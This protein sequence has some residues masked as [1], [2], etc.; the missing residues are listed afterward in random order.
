MRA[1]QVIL[2]WANGSALTYKTGVL[3]QTPMTHTVSGLISC[4]DLFFQD[5]DA[6]LDVPDSLLGFARNRA[7]PRFPYPGGQEREIVKDVL[8]GFNRMKIWKDYL[9]RHSSCFGG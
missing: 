2:I 7:S 5:C 8:K 3:S 6:V 9:G 4:N 1:S